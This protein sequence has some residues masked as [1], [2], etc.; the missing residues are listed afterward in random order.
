MQG[1]V[2]DWDC[3]TGLLASCQN[4]TDTTLCT[5]VQVVRSALHCILALLR[6]LWCLFSNKQLLFFLDWI[7]F[8][9]NFLKGGNPIFPQYFVRIRDAIPFFRRNVKTLGKPCN[10]RAFNSM[11][12]NFWPKSAWQSCRLRCNKSC[13]NLQKIFWIFPNIVWYSQHSWIFVFT[14]H[15]N[16]WQKYDGLSPDQ[17]F[18]EVH[19][20]CNVNVLWRTSFNRI[21][22]SVQVK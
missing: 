16:A 7:G 6:E 9:V 22:F 21:M 13:I 3:W 18:Y 15:K 4:S 20:N 12:P 17:M 2:I 14:K 5:A 19:S 11:S 1:R 8:F 10:L